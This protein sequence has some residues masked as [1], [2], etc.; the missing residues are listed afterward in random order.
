MINKTA[1]YASIREL[2]RKKRAEYSIQT[3][4]FGIREIRAIYR[5]EHITIDIRTLPSCLKA[6]YLA[7]EGDVCVAI[8]KDLP[9]EPKLFALAHELKHH[10]ADQELIQAGLF[11]CGDYNANELEEKGAEVFAAEFIYPEEEFFEDV[12]ACNSPEWKPQDIVRFKKFHCRGKVSYTFIRKR[13]ELRGL[14]QRDQFAGVKFQKLEEEMYGVPF[15][16]QSWFRQRRP[17]SS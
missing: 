9:G 5:R 17:S 14:V 13:L 6:I 3:N 1:Y 10:W 16:R 7:Q 11:R 15:Y 4:A 2:A 12:G 8:R